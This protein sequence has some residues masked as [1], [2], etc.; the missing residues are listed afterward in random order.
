MTFL[1]IVAVLADENVSFVRNPEQVMVVS[2]NLLI[3]PD[4]HH[5]Q[6]IRLVFDQ[7]M[8]FKH[9]LNVVKVNELVNYTVGIAGYIT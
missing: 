2:H 1:I 6:I 7:L 8:Q 5:C 9:G 4:E 3:G